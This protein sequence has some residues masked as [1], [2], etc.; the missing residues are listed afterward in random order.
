[1]K[2]DHGVKSASGADE[3]PKDEADQVA[4]LDPRQEEADRVRGG[5]SVGAPVHSGWDLQGNKG[6]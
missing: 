5:G 2:D 6:A 1:M 4:D 3:D